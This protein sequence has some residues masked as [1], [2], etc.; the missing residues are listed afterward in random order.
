MTQSFVRTAPARETF[1]NFLVLTIGVIKNK[2]IKVRITVER[3]TYFRISSKRTHAGD[4]Y[5]IKRYT[6][7]DSQI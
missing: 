7:Y 3:S 6:K 2:T 5:I 1:I 4:V